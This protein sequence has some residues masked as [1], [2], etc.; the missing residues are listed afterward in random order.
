[1]ATIQKRGDTYR[2]TASD[3]YDSTGKQ[4]RKSTTYKPARG[5]TE[6]QVEKELGRQAVLFEELVKNG[7]Y[8]KSN[9]KFCDLADLWFNEHAE[10]QLARKTVHE[11]RKQWKRIAPALGHFRL[12]RLKPIHFQKFYNTLQEDG[13]NKKTGGKLSPSTIRRYHA[14]MSSMFSMAILW[15]ILSVNPLRVKPPKLV[16]KEA[17]Y[18]DETQA[19]A[20]LDALESEPLPYKAMIYILLYTGVR[21]GELLGLEW[22]D[23]D[24]D[25]SLIHIMRASQYIPEQGI[26]TKEPKNKTSQRVIK[27]PDFI[28]DMLRLLRHEQLVERMAMGDKWQD[29]DRLFTM[30][31]GSPIHPDTLPRWFANFLK[32]NDLPYINIH[33]LRHTCASLM[34]ASHVDIRTV[35][36]RLGH[37]MPSTTTNIYAHAIR[38]AD[39]AA[40]EAID[41]ALKRKRI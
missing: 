12:E 8:L 24:F 3:G 7:A 17:V 35:A 19:A 33:G 10:K 6:K 37:A 27:V 31:D 34:I 1:M 20:L 15:G 2:I 38:S 25:K 39:E 29:R 11:Y 40:A 18:L 9:M 30:W 23:I 41:L 21:K 5:M 16:Q 36:N 26:I 13:M 32:A 22:K 4:M 14:L 28:F